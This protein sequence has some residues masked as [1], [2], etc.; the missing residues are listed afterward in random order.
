MNYKQYVLASLGRL[1]TIYP[2]GRGQ[3]KMEEK[4]A[5]MKQAKKKREQGKPSA[6][7]DH[8]TRTPV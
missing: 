2:I 7:V 4:K 1:E 8:I 3:K 5:E 6:F